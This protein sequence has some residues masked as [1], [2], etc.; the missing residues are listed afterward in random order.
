MSR[1]RV[2]AALSGGVDSSVAALLLQR[3]GYDVVGVFLRNGVEKPP[4]RCDLKQGCCSEDDALDAAKVADRLG[5]PFHALDMAAEFRGVM[6]YFAAEYERGR[7]PNPCAVCN[8]DIKFGALA[9]FAGAIGADHLATGH[10]AQTRRGA[11]GV[12]L[13]R[14]AD[15]RKDQSYVLFPIGPAVLERTLLPIG[16]MHKSATRRL[17]EEAGLPVFAKPDSVEICFVPTGDYRDLLRARGSLG[18]PGRILHCDGRT[19][20]EHDGHAGFTRGQRR[21]LGVASGEP[22]Y[23]LDVDAASG[24]VTVGPRSATSCPRATVEGFHTFAAPWAEGE[25]REEDLTVQYRSSPGGVPAAVRRLAGDRAEVR[26][27]QPAV[28]V[29]PGQGLAVYRGDQLVA[30]GWI[31]HADLPAALAV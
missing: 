8:R 21:K 23:V 5:I 3:Q 9:R 26:F 29:T 20:G 6:D 11:H 24:D 12:E 25:V 17:A 27:R 19:L 1:P 13:W 4:N 22:L 31:E 14:G 18:R 16:G 2:L 10:Y 30:G 7:T 15:P 28:S